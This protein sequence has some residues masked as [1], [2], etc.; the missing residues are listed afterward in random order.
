MRDYEG[1]GKRPATQVGSNFHQRSTLQISA[2]PKKWGLNQAKTG[3]GSGFVGLCA[4]DV[5][6]TWQLKRRVAVA[7]RIF[8]S[9]GIFR[10]ASSKNELSDVPDAGDLLAI[11]GRHGAPDRLDW[12]R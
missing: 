3:E 11:E 8:P 1:H 2:N 6:R 7:V 4:V 12:Q 5:Q 9:N 10:P